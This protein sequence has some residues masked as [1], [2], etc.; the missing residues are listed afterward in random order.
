MHL[1]SNKIKEF[2]L[3][4]K[5]FQFSLLITFF[6]VHSCS[7][8][9]PQY[10]KQVDSP[11]ETFQE[12]EIPTHRFFLIGDTGDAGEPASTTTFEFFKS[13][14]DKADSAS[15]VIFLGDNIY[16]N[17]M[18]DENSNQRKKAEQKL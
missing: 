16:P 12:S 15:T 10:G 14:I 18:P 8:I 9:Q 11:K 4:K 17:G 7:T 1:I 2:H 5:L 6:F 3:A 13:R